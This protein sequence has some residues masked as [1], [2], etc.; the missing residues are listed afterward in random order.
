MEQID[1]LEKNET[2]QII[3]LKYIC[4][5]GGS[6]KKSDIAKHLQT[7]IY[8]VTKLIENLVYLAN[9]S[10]GNFFITLDK[11]TVYFRTKASYSLNKLLL[12]FIVQAPKYK[13]LEELFLTGTTDPSRLCEKINISYSTYFRKIHELND[14][15]SEFELG[16]QNGVLQGSELQIRY[17]FLSIYS[18]VRSNYISQFTN[19]DPRI[20][21]MIES[22][23]DKIEAPLS[24]LSKQ[25]LLFYF[26][27]LK[28]RYVQNKNTNFQLLFFNEHLLLYEESDFFIQLKKSQFYLD[29]QQ[30][31]NSFLNYYSFKNCSKEALLFTLFLLGENILPTNSS[32]FTNLKDIENENPFF[33]RLFSND[34]FTF[35]KKRHPDNSLKKSQKNQLQHYLELLIYKQTIFKGSLIKFY[36]TKED[37]KVQSNNTLQLFINHLKLKYP[38]FFNQIIGNRLTLQ[39][40]SY[41]VDYYEQC[42]KSRITVGVFIEDDFLYSRFLTKWWVGQVNLTTIASAEEL[43]QNKIYDLVISNIDYSNIKSKGKQFLLITHQ[44]EKI[45]L[46]DLN[47]VLT[48]LYLS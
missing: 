6:A 31:L 34:F 24:E 5:V 35:M 29:I 19:L 43:K 21:T 38:K 13:I 23:N 4:D 14:L 15:L 1:L 28:K 39:Q 2:N 42:I 45:D 9:N 40:L 26:I 22:I 8:F 32:L 27:T 18:A 25:K 3:L 30:L 41:A 17:F 11:T 10:N 46:K 20:Q 12:E 36:Q 16:I 7:G 37:R 47:K 33:I 44:N 48:E